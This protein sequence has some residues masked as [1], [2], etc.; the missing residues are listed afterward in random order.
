[1]RR[2]TGDDAAATGPVRLMAHPRYF[3]YTFNPA[4][5][6]YLYKPGP[7]PHPALECVVVQVTNTPW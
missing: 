1:M 5:F 2:T 3:G 7:G 4:A 6:F